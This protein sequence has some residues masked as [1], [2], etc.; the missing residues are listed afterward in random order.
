MT[1]KKKI[2]TVIQ[3]YKKVTSFKLLKLIATVLY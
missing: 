2:S 3:N 1:G